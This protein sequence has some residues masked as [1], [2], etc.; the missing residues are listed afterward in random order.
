MP[1]DS[2]TT[3]T[4]TAI[5]S[6]EFSSVTL[7]TLDLSLSIPTAQPVIAYVASVREPILAW[8]GEPLD[9]DAVLDDIAT[10]VEQVIQV[11][12]SFRA[13]THMGVFICR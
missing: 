4:G 6:R 10:K 11:Q 5:L 13:T 2:F 3:Q 8:I 7:R 12:G 9:F 1:A